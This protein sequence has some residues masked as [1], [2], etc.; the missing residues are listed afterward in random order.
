M[1]RLAD[2]SS[3]N[4]IDSLSNSRE[5]QISP[6]PAFREEARRGAS[7]SGK[8]AETELTTCLTRTR[9]IPD[10][11]SRGVRKRTQLEQNVQSGQAAAGR[12]GNATDQVSCRFKAQVAFESDTDSA[13]N[14]MSP[15]AAAAFQSQSGEPPPATTS[16]KK[17]L[18]TK[19]SYA[20]TD[21]QP[22]K[23]KHHLSALDRMGLQ[24]DW[25]YSLRVNRMRG[26]KVD[27][28]VR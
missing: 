5:L 27:S 23:R 18:L 13:S 28:K 21:R 10:K 2:A 25:D 14:S 12:K 26:A 22:D 9:R 8:P 4:P 19:T 15:S 7:P 1:A 16:P 6:P 11:P 17:E 24:P 3:P 20:R